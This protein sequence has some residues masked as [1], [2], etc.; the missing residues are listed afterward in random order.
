MEQAKMSDDANQPKV[1]NPK[2]G[3]KPM[4]KDD[5][6]SLPMAEMQAKLESSPEGLS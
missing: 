5:L 1:P 4:A 2:S 3:P 6:K